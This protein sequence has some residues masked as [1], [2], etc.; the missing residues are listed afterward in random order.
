MGILYNFLRKRKNWILP[1][2]ERVQIASVMASA[3]E[4][5]LNS[6]IKSLE[7]I[8]PDLSNQY[9]AH[10]IEKDVLKIR[11]RSLHAFQMQLFLSVIELIAK[12][13]DY[14]NGFTIADIGDSSGTHQLYIKQLLNNK[15]MFSANS[16]NLISVSCDPLAVKRIKSKGLKAILCRAENL[17]KEKNIDVNLF[18]SFEMLEH[19]K[20]PV[21]FLNLLSKDSN[22]SHF[23]LTVPYLKTSRVGLHHIRNKQNKR[24]YSANTHIFE[25][26]PE[27]WRLIFCLTGWKPVK[28]RIYL[29]YPKWSFFRIT[30]SIWKKFDFEGFYGVYLKKD[31][32]WADNYH[33]EIF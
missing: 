19:L 14:Q 21:S 2:Y 17:F 24:V 5:R 8:V 11:V 28:E 23:L 29:Q 9:V 6:T 13:K 20:D 12:E 32:E 18:I 27:D 25:L 7:E 26:C 3:K 16:L 33:D 22:C 31:R 30:K 10:T 1:L 15:R 4:Y